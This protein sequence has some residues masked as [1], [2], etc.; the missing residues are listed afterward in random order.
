MSDILDFCRV[1]RISLESVYR[2]LIRYRRH[3]LPSEHHRPEDSVILRSL[4]VD[5]L[6]QLEVPVLAFLETDGYEIHRARC[7]CALDFRNQQSRNNSVCVKARD[8]EMYGALRGRL[9]A[10]L[11]ALFKIMNPICDGTVQALAS[12]QILRPVNYRYA[13]DVHDLVT[14]QQ[15]EDAPEF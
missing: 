5:L 14:V 13:S 10:K 2:E 4:P 8:K 11:L 6:K 3:N 7:T 1:L 12:V 15:S 9:P